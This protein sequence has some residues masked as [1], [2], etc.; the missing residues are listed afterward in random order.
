[1]AKTRAKK[2]GAGKKP[3]GRSKRAPDALIYNAP[4]NY[5]GYYKVL[6]LCRAT[7]SDHVVLYLTTLGGDADAAYRIAR[8]L[9]DSYSHVTVEVVSFCK[10]AGTLV[11]L[12]ADALVMHDAGELGPLDVQLRK[13][14]ELDEAWSGNDLQQGLV[15]ATQH[16]LLTF[17]EAFLDICI[18]AG[19]G[20]TLSGDTA[21]A[22]VTGLYAR[23]FEQIDPARLG[24]VQRANQVGLRY[25]N[26]LAGPDGADSATS[27]A[28][29]ELV[30]GYPSHSFVIDRAEA[31]KL[32]KNVRDPTKDE[33]DSAEAMLNLLRNPR[34]EQDVLIERIPPRETS[35][36]LAQKP[37]TTR[38]NGSG[39]GSGDGDRAAG[40]G[41]RS[42]EDHAGSQAGG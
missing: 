16:A 21:A 22:V 33:Q 4:I 36:E 38:S 20:A 30:L 11:A 1:M 13:R 40:A 9:R 42:K 2:N 39:D 32:F 37:T 26:L 19:L 23:I 27:Q 31:S 14:E 7:T 8:C 24:Q 18:N 35:D 25:A 10:S 3:A 15:H 17:R 34:D 29:H 6:D 41:V 5:T 28:V 12:A